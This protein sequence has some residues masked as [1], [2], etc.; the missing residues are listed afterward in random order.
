MPHHWLFDQA[1]LI[2]HHGGFGTTA[3]G[4][5]AGVP[6]LVIPHIIDQFYWGQR[7][8]QLGV[9]PQPISRGQLTVPKLFQAISLAQ[10]DV[11]MRARAYALGQIIRHEADGVT[12][13]VDLI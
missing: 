9:G 2:I 12:S 1:S 13:A 4:L 8:Y 10:F 6:S 3:A 11:D 7:V 5:R